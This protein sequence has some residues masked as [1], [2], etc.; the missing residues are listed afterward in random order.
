MS[1]RPWRS[2]LLALLVAAAGTAVAINPDARHALEEGGNTVV[3]WSRTLRDVAAG[4]PDTELAA[5]TL[6]G[7]SASLLVVVGE[8]EQTAFALIAVGPTGTP[9]VTVMP[10]DLLLSVPGYGE[11]R[12]GQAHQFDGARLAALA[13][14]NQ[15]GIR[16]DR[17]AEIP[18]GGVATAVG[19]PATIDLASAFFVD[20][21]TTIIRQ[22]PAGR[23]VVDPEILEELLVVSGADGAFEWIQRQGAAW[24]AVLAAVAEEPGIADRLLTDRAGRDAADLLVTVAA[25]TETVIAT[26]PVERADTGAARDAL[27]PVTGR[28][29]SFVVERLGHLLLR[30]AGRPR[31][32][33]LNGNGRIGSTRVVADI[34]VRNGFWLIRTDNADTFEYEDTLVIAQGEAAEP[35]AREVAA[36]LGHGL[37]FLEVR[38]PSGVVDVS[39]IVG[40]DVPTGEG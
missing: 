29:D 13:I 28:A 32:E 40:A 12:L 15:F 8:G 39:I 6:T 25:S 19:R 11:F 27:A 7:E 34:L 22:L 2:V 37:L 17:F 9:T 24:R 20:D 26:I 36:L 30:P 38:A 21:G 35:V 31:I 14:T 1:R 18:G 3:G 10:Q 23:S 4:L 16:I 33:I 5:R